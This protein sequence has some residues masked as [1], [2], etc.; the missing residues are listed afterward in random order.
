MG[1]VDADISSRKDWEDTFVK[2]LDVLGF[3]YEERWNRGMARVG[4]FYSAC[5]SSHTLPSR[6]HVETFPAAG[7]VGLRFLGKIQKKKRSC[8]ARKPI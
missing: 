2:G 5:R 8:T 7:P 3:Q 6:N 1:A 4:V